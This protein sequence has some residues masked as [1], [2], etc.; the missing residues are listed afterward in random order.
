M[1]EIWITNWKIRSLLSCSAALYKLYCFGQILY[2]ML[3]TQKEETASQP[4]VKT[5][6]QIDPRPG[7]SKKPAKSTAQST[8]KNMATN[9]KRKLTV[10]ESNENIRPTKKFNHTCL[11][12]RDEK[13]M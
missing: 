13:T 10:E 9:T 4:Q 12:G 8:R 3:C 2:I 1:L 11:Q 6:E 7:K 5:K